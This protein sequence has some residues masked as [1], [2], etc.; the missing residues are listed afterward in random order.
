MEGSQSS[1]VSGRYR[2]A[3]GGGHKTTSRLASATRHL[4]SY[5]SKW[6]K[7]ESCLVEE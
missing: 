2:T 1:V 5:I 3:P 6:T 7:T 4:S